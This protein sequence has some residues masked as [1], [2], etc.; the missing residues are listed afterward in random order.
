MPLPIRLC[1]FLSASVSLPLSL[2]LC[3]PA[4]VSLPLFLCL[5]LNASVSLPLSLCL[6]ASVSLPLSLCLCLPASVSMPLFL[7]LC[8]NAYVSLP[9]SLCICLPA[10]VS[11][12]PICLL[13]CFLFDY[14]MFYVLFRFCLYFRSSIRSVWLAQTRKIYGF[15]ALFRDREHPEQ[16]PVHVRRTTSLDHRCSESSKRSLQFSKRMRSFTFFSSILF[17]ANVS[18]RKLFNYSFFHKFFRS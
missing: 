7:C 1:L 15:F 2:C 13:F 16:P 18:E 11:L 3:L 9:L 17:L 4:S 6:S 12:A 5:C 10:A 14:S 8:L